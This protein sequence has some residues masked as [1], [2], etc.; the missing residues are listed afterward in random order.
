MYYTL[1]LSI[2]I[3]KINV[4]RMWLI[5]YNERLIIFVYDCVLQCEHVYTLENREE[6]GDEAIII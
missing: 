2:I 5:V 4:G 3:I 1:C 6:P